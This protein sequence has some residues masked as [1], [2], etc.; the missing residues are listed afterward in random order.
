MGQNAEAVLRDLRTGDEISRRRLPGTPSQLR[1]SP[2]GERFAALCEV[3][4][5]WWA[6]PTATRAESAETN[7]GISGFSVPLRQLQRF[8]V[9]PHRADLA[10]GAT[11]AGA[12]LSIGRN[13]ISVYEHAA[14][15][16][17]S[18]LVYSNAVS[19][20]THVALVYANRRPRLYVNGALVR[21][22]TTVTFPFIHASAGLGGSTQGDFGNFRG[23]LDEV[24][25]WNAALSETQI[26]TNMSRSLTGA[27]PG[28]V[29]YFR[30]DE[31]GGGVLLDAASASPNFNGTL[32][33]GASF[34]F[35]GVVPFGGGN[36]N[37]SGA[38]ESCFV[39]SG[40]FDTNAL[41]S[42]R[43]LEVTGLP[44][45]CDPPKPCPG[46]SEL[47]S[48]PVRHVL[49]HF[50]NA[51]PN[52][53]CVTAQLQLDCP[54]MPAGLIGVAAYVGEFRVNQPCSSFLGDDGA[55]GPP[56]PPFSFRV[57][58]RTNFLLVVVTARDTNLLC[59]SYALE[60]FG[61]PC[62]PPTLHIAKDAAPNKVLLQWSSAYPDYRLQSASV[63][64]SS[65]PADFNN[66]STPPVLTE[67][68]FVV[69]NSATISSQFYRLRSP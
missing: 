10:Y 59:D 6:N 3:A 36:C 29:T 45:V 67:G 64:N 35:P 9:F 27:E 15:F 56:A 20:W 49:H 58:P 66:V 31:G 13:G 16:L 8:A 47:P 23:Q 52:E 57:P 55:F 21:S 62:P 5:A 24:R 53:L 37:G 60:L 28:L 42:V 33:D 18:R 65:G 63:L 51:T 30:C 2:D 48:E 39:V 4:D 17:P 61:L 26:Q 38:C 11:H 69:T 40:H 43:R 12:G 19:G 54:G 34:V 41:E 25:I 44:S 32:A 50:T 1:F 46:F 22:S 14:N 7:N 68:R